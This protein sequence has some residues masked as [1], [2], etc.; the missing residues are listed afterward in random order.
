MDGECAPVDYKKEILQFI[1]DLHDVVDK[2]FA[3]KL[4]QLGQMSANGFN[5]ALE[6]RRAIYI[7]SVELGAKERLVKLQPADTKLF[8]GKADGSFK[9]KEDEGGLQGKMK[10]KSRKTTGQ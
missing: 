5:S 7:N 2:K 6:G 9:A 1:N 8:G 4:E 10:F 3:G